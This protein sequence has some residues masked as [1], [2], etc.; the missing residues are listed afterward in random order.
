MIDTDVL[1]T[2]LGDADDDDFDETVV[3]RLR[4]KL[5]DLEQ[6][7]GTVRNVGYRFNVYEDD[8][9][10]APKERSGT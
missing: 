2:G 7:I 3:R 1:D 8:Q 4:A 5:G 10:P 6:L 9:V